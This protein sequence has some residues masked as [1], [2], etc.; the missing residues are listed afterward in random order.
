MPA[1]M[2]TH[3]VEVLLNNSHFPTGTS[4][5]QLESTQYSLEAI[6]QGVPEPSRFFLSITIRWC[7]HIFSALGR[8]FQLTIQVIQEVI[9]QYDNPQRRKLPRMWK[10]QGHYKR[11]GTGNAP[12]WKQARLIL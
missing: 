9:L 7:C 1:W 11:Q 4:L 3:A 12:G 2:K 6:K 10:T 8:G 5:P